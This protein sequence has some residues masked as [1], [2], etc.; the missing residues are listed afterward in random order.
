MIKSVALPKEYS[1]D[2]VAPD[3]VYGKSAPIMYVLVQGKRDEQREV[4]H[5]LMQDRQVGQG[6]E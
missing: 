6:K 5:G 4:N 2:A 3:T 1:T